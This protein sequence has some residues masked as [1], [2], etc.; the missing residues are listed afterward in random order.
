MR[1]DTVTKWMRR[2]APAVLL[3]L[4]GA[5]PLLLGCA[6]SKSKY[7]LALSE[8]DACRL[9]AEQCEAE[10]MDLGQKHQNLLLSLQQFEKNHQDLLDQLAALHSENEEL[11][12][13]IR[14]LQEQTKKVKER[15]QQEA[16]QVYRNVLGSLSSELSQGKIRIDQSDKGLRLNLVDKILFSSGSADL[17]PKGEE[18]LEKVGFVLKDIRDRKILIE[19]HADNVPIRAGPQSRFRSNW[20]LSAARAAAVARFFEEKVGIDPRLLSATGYSSYRPAFDNST[21]EGRQANRRIEIILLPLT[22]SEIQSLYGSGPH[23]SP[24]APPAGPD[25]LPGGQGNSESPGENDPTG[26]SVPAQ[27]AET[28]KGAVAP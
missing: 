24:M 6:V 12:K 20:E 1:S 3:P 2:L 16:S 15:D 23:P 14:S 9:H 22:P 13:R 10:K 18:I 27:E 25:S 7:E 8:R 4:F 21:P 17:S 5:L 19:G 28:R 26:D 11:A